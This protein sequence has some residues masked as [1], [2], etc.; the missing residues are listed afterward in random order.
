PAVLNNAPYD[1][2]CSSLVLHDMIGK[3]PQQAVGR[4]VQQT[5]KYLSDGGCL[6]F[7]DVFIESE[8]R[9]E[10]IAYWRKKMSQ[11]GLSQA[12]IKI[13]MDENPEMLNTVTLE[14]L[15]EVAKENGFLPP[16]LKGV[17]A[18]TSQWPFR[19]LVMKKGAQTS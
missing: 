5:S 12:S 16:E 10:Q 14:Q 18:T 15:G 8:S 6:I 3:Q 2:I 19:V 1:L 17:P 4:V 9:E 13:F 11:Q 7:A